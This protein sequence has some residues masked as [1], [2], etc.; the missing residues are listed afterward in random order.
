MIRIAYPSEIDKILTLTQACAKDMI[1]QGIYQWND[2]YPSRKAFSEDI[3]R[4][5]LFVYVFKYGII[6]C[7]VLTEIEDA[8]YNKVCWGTP[9]AAKT[10]YVHRLAVHPQ[11]QG[12][13]IGQQ[14]MDFGENHA[15]SQNYESIRLDTFSL[16]PRNQK[17]YEQRGYQRLE[18]IYL[19]DQS[20][21][22][23][24]CYELLLSHKY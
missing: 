13:G 2:H 9:A 22:P 17:F 6:G 16:N 14:L 15:R 3:A 23:F 11:H 20:E 12:Q 4:N 1:A 7:I 10:Q 18:S 24:F 8:A 19:P 21:Y 5:E